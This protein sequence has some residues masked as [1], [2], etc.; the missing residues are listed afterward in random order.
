[1]II[2]K[3]FRAQI[4]C[5]IGHEV[6]LQAAPHKTKRYLVVVKTSSCN[7]KSHW[8]RNVISALIHLSFDRVTGG[9]A[10]WYWEAAWKMANITAADTLTDNS[11]SDYMTRNNKL[12]V[13]SLH[14]QKKTLFLFCWML[15]CSGAPCLDDSYSHI[16]PILKWICWCLLDTLH[17]YIG[18]KHVACLYRPLILISLSMCLI[19]FLNYTT[20]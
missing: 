4:K 18:H 12:K 1:M 19:S 15:T 6:K 10:C 2:L 20:G 17:I 8:H 11:P 5:M 3:H 13:C 9:E 14:L 16:Y 7:I